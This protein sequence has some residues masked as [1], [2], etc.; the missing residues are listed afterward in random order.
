M[1][2]VGVGSCCPGT[3]KS[4]PV[5]EGGLRVLSDVRGDTGDGHPPEKD[6]DSPRVGVERRTPMS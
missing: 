6:Q 5:K 1:V 4:L 3:P 2:G